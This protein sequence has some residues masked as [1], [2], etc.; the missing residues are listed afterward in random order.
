MAGGQG[1]SDDYIA[2]FA[3]LCSNDLSVQINLLGFFFVARGRCTWGNIRRRSWLRLLVN[4]AHL[5]VCG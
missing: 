2:V 5:A 3:V 1:R 4:R